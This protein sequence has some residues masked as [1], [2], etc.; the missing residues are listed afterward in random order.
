MGFALSKPKGPVQL[1]EKIE[2]TKKTEKAEDSDLEEKSDSNKKSEKP[3]LS[4][5]SDNLL[6]PVIMSSG[7]KTMI[8]LGSNRPGDKLRTMIYSNVCPLARL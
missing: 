1:E 5:K 3:D 7:I 6:T 2:Q 4:V 8:I